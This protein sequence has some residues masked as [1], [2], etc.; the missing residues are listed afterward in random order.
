MLLCSCSDKN[1]QTDYSQKNHLQFTD[2]FPGNRRR[3]RGNRFNG[4]LTIGSDFS[5][6]LNLI[7]LQDNQ[8]AS[9]TVGA[10]QYSKTLM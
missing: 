9:I 3:F 6:Q 2:T 4:T 7:D 10:S 5:T 8:I 1:V